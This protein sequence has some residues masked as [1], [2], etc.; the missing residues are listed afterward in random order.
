MALLSFLE[1]F[2]SNLISIL[3]GIIL[4]FDFFCIYTAFVLDA[5]IFPRRM[6]RIWVPAGIFVSA[7]FVVL[8]ILFSKDVVS[9]ALFFFIASV[10]IVMGMGA[11]LYLKYKKESDS[12]ITKG[13]TAPL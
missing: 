5:V 7:I 8:Y 13:Q 3:I 4:A 9:R 10:L 1:P 2:I 11:F 12:D 6:S